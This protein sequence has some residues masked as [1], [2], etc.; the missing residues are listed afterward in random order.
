LDHKTF[1]L[2]LDASLLLA[3][4]LLLSPRLTGLPAHEWLGIAFC[5]PVLLH[6]LL[7]WD[8]IL[9]TG[10]GLL[11]GGWRKRV[12]FALN[13]LL[14][15]LTATAVVS[16]VAIS[17][18]ALPSAGLNMVNDRSWRALHNLPLN[19]LLLIVGLHLAM[20]WSWIAAAVYHRRRNGVPPPEARMRVAPSVTHLLAR[21]TLIAAAVAAV[22]LGV[23]ALLGPPTPARL[24]S[25]DEVARFTPSLGH[26]LGQLLGESL[27]L[28][29]AAYVGRR[30][31]RVRM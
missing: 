6:L 4:V 15:V 30:W 19:W 8:W 12:N 22:A 27:L 9:K 25:Q 21:S 14:F 17:Q 18:V 1:T 2:Y 31:L 26:G 29:L 13:T 11:H 20:N 7:A 3:F 10:K 28:C 16:G 23:L 5:V 24:Y